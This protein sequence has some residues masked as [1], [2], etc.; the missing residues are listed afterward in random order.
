M[1]K[2]KESHQD[3][4]LLPCACPTPTKKKKEKKRNISPRHSPL[5][6][7]LLTPTKKKKKKK[8][9]ISPRHSPLTLYLL[10]P[11]KKK[12]KKKKKYLTKTFSSYPVPI[13]PQNKR[14]EKEKKNS[15]QDILL[16]PCRY[17]T[18]YTYQEGKEKEK[19]ISPRHFPLTLDLPWERKRKKG[20][21]PPNQDLSPNRP[22]YTKERVITN[23]LPLGQASLPG[24]HRGRHT[25]VPPCPGPPTSSSSPYLPYYTPPRRG[26]NWEI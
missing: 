6:L 26:V 8:R 18:Y 17:P 10:T 13:L 21:S 4:L 7:Y 15:H 3:S 1:K 20:N 24:T 16:L 9:N 19:R 22:T 11:T 12:K 25:H 2:E 23:V 14:I 5:T